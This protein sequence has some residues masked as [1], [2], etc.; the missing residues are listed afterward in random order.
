ME[1]VD[2]GKCRDES[3][4]AFVEKSNDICKPYSK[5]VPVVS[6][7]TTNDLQDWLLDRILVRYRKS[8]AFPNGKGVHWQRM[9]SPWDGAGSGRVQA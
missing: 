5:R 4:K 7:E 9:D 3:L 6:L 2:V 1:Q 8:G